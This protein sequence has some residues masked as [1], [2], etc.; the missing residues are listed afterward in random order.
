MSDPTARLATHQGHFHIERELG[1]GMATVLS[2]SDEQRAHRLERAVKRIEDEAEDLQRH[3][4]EQGLRITGLAENHRGVGLTL[5][6]RDVAFGDR[7]SNGGA[8]GQGEVHLP[9]GSQANGTPRVFGQ[10]RVDRPAVD[11]EADGAL[12]GGT[13]HGTLDVAQPHTPEDGSFPAGTLTR[14][15]HPGTE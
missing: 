10:Q 14:I 4:A 13:T 2:S 11:Q 8:V 1:G 12:A 3:D 5:R 7:S 6:Q 9:P 15:S